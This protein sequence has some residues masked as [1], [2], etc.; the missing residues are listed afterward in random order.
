MIWRLKNWGKARD[1]PMSLEHMKYQYFHLTPGSPAPLAE[2]SVGCPWG[3]AD[4]VK[5]HT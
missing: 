1:T 2:P 3:S 4:Y 5:A